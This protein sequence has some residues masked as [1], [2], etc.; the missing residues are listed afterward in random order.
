MHMASLCKRTVEAL[1]DGMGLR[2]FVMLLRVAIGWR[3]SNHCHALKI[4]R[5]S[6]ALGS[7]LRQ[8]MLQPS[9]HNN[10]SPNVSLP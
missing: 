9:R 10:R 2:R 1:I 7:F 8:K 4:S 3:L 6:A 5:C